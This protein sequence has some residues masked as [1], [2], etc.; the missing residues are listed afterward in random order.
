MQDSG[1]LKNLVFGIPHCLHT[2]TDYSSA[3]LRVTY[4]KPEHVFN[5]HPSLSTYIWQKSQVVQN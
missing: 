4:Y 1:T 3:F 2:K 5:S